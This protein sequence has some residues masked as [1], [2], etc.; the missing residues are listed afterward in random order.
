MI[1]GLQIDPGK[2]LNVRV[3]VRTMVAA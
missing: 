3:A 1:S 2:S